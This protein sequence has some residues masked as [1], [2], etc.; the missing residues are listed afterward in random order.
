MFFLYIAW[1]WA[2]ISLYFVPS[3]QDWNPRF[4]TA[5]LPL[6]HGLLHYLKW[7]SYSSRPCCR[8]RAV[9]AYFGANPRQRGPLS[10]LLHLPLQPVVS[11]SR[12]RWRQLAGGL[13]EKT[14]TDGGILLS[15]ALSPAPRHRLLLNL[16]REGWPW[17][18]CVSMVGSL[19]LGSWTFFVGQLHSH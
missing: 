1:C 6:P 15:P 17:I 18:K 12:R 3:P 11:G 2:I 14:A 8:L 10:F 4:A 16:A 19:F 9:A 5:P 13:A 7:R